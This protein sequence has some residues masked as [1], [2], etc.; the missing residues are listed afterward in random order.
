MPSNSNARNYNWLRAVLGAL[1]ACNLVAAFFLLYPPGGSAE[2]LEQQSVALR[3]QLGAKRKIVTE[4]R[5]H[6]A[7]VEKGRGEGDGFLNQYFLARRT[8]YATLLG[9]LVAAANQAGIK[10]RE[11]SY[12][13]EPIEGSDTLDMMT[14]TANYEGTYANLLRFVHA[15]DKSP[16]LLIIEGLS[17]APLQG[18]NTLS[19]NMKMEAF[20]REDGSALEQPAGALKA[21]LTSQ[22]PTR[23]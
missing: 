10:A 1:V 19:V 17:A 5:Q 3:A 21:V 9:E 18:A 22:E 16:R 11:H 15:V 7:A 23:P 14:I 13:M 4:M 6:V 20:V 12:A 8:A 2:E